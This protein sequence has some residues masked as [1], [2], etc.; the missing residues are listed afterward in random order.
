M[1]GLEFSGSTV[2]MAVLGFFAITILTI[3]FLRSRFKGQQDSLT[4]KYKD[5][6]WKSPLH[7]RT[8]YPEVDSFDYY[9]PFM[10]WG[11]LVATG[12]TLFAMNWTQREVKSGV[13]MEMGTLDDE[14]EVEP[15]RTSEPP[16][17]PPPPPPPVISEVP[18][19]EVIED[20]SFEDNSLEEEEAIVDAPVAKV[21]EKKAPPPPPPPPPAPKVEEEIFKIVE[22]MPR[23]PGCEN[24]KGGNEEKKK[25]ADMKLLEYLGKTVKYPAI[26]RENGIE[27][28]AVIQFTVGKTGEIEDVIVLRDP[29]AGLGDAAKEAVETMNKMKDKWV[30]GKQRGVPVKVQYTVPLKFKLN[31]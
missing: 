8:K 11:L 6:T 17:P 25:C 14:I 21:E 10:L 13:V 31:T 30:P 3:F 27:G 23:F 5:S 22:Q 24:E 9:R 26:A 19:E 28:Q 16:P 15:P 20:V 2:A 12:T 1:T 7:A 29:G 18:D 4:E